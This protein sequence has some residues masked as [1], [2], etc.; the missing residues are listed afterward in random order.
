MTVRIG[1]VALQAD[2]AELVVEILDPLR[3]EHHRKS[4]Q[5]QPQPGSLIGKTVDSPKITATDRKISFDDL[6]QSERHQLGNKLLEGRGGIKQARH[7]QVSRPVTGA[8]SRNTSR[9][10]RGT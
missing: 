6:T 5:L 4:L 1:R 8:P 3:V 10:K 7:R 9:G 2:P